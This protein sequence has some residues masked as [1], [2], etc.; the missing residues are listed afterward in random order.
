MNRRRFLAILLLC[1]FTGVVVFALYAVWNFESWAVGLHQKSITRELAA[2]EQD[3]AR[4][5]NWDEADHAIGMLEYV[6]NY[7]VPGPGYRSNPQT[8]A[9][10][11]SQRA[12][13]LAAIAVALREFTGEDFGTDAERWRAWRNEQLCWP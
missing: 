13:T 1:G 2:W 11:E 7:Y 6:Q 10:L 9:A 5:T 8:E 3:E 4:V 12:R